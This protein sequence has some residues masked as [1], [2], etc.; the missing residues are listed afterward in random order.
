L[1]VVA[2]EAPPQP[3]SRDDSRA[4]SA[5]SPNFRLRGWFQSAHANIRLIAAGIGSLMRPLKVH[6]HPVA[7]SPS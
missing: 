3:T 5:R 6:I 1:T 4:A 7:V 2:G